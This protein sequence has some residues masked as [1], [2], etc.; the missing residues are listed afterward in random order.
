MTVCLTQEQESMNIIK[1]SVLEE[2]KSKKYD[3]LVLLCPSSNVTVKGINAEIFAAYPA[4][5]QD[6]YSNKYPLRGVV[7]SSSKSFD[8]T[9]LFAYMQYYSGRPSTILNNSGYAFDSKKQR[10]SYIEE[11]MKLINATFKERKVLIPAVDVKLI[12]LKQVV[13]NDIIKTYC[14]D[15]KVTIVWE[16]IKN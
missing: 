16:H 5:K 12:G 11:C 10:Y 7:K 9:V 2:F 4:V 3:A 13:V 1:G 14:K 15:C 8:G 6:Y